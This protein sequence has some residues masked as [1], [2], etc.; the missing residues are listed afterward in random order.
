MVALCVARACPMCVA[1]AEGTPTP[2]PSQPTP[3]TGPFLPTA[4]APTREHCAGPTTR[5]KRTG[6]GM[7]AAVALCV[8]CAC[9]VCVAIAEGTPT[10]NPSQPA[11]PT[12]RVIIFWICT[13][14]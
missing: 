12:G 4:R 2:N 1:I 3:P 9:P 11:P 7:T 14:T 10:H 6:G 5:D 8:T 13:C